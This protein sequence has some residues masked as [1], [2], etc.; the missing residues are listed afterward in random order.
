MDKTDEKL[1]EYEETQ[2]RIREYAKQEHVKNQKRIN[3][4]IICILVIPIIFL[5]L[6]FTM[7]SSKIVFLVF[8]IVS[9]FVISGYLIITEYR[10]YS[11]KKRLE[12]LGIK[13]EE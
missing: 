8:W 1:I 4:G 12:E 5:V 2:K 13:E 9:L 3:A 7:N 11:L 6:L 10:D